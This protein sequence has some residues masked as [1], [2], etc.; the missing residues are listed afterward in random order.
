[1]GAPFAVLKKADE[2]MFEVK[3]G[4]TPELVLLNTAELEYRG[5]LGGNPPTG[6]ETVLVRNFRGRLRR[7]FGFFCSC[8]DPSISPEEGPGKRLGLLTRRA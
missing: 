7:C 6:G 3:V 5:S 4:D 2:G 1:V 8:E